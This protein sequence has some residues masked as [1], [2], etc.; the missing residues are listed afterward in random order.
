MTQLSDIGDEIRFQLAKIEPKPGDVLVLT[1]PEGVTVQSEQSALIAEMIAGKLPEGVDI[2]LVP[3]G[4][5]LEL[6]QT[7]KMVKDRKVVVERPAQPI[8]RWPQNQEHAG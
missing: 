3:H 4:W 7:W 1:Y 5:K 2:I 6:Q 8:M